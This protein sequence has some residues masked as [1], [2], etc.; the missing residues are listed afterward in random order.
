MLYY[1]SDIKLLLIELN[2]NF[3]RNVCNILCSKKSFL[4]FLNIFVLYY[5]KVELQTN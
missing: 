5:K 3:K 1:D 2:L 4:L